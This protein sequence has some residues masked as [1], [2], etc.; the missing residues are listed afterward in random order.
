[1]FVWA[2]PDFFFFNFFFNLLIF[3]PRCRGKGRVAAG[4]AAAGR[5]E[6]GAEPHIHAAQHSAGGDPEPHG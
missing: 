6:A 5:A 2:K 4:A 3:S 1:M